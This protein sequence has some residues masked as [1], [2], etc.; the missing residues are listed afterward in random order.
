M[1]TAKALKNVVILLGVIVLV[2]GTYFVYRY[3]TKH[4]LDQ[5]RKAIHEKSNAVILKWTDQSPS[6]L[7]QAIMNV[8]LELDKPVLPKVKIILEKSKS[9]EVRAAAAFA[10][11]LFVAKDG[12][13]R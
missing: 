9:E 8:A 2:L 1:R 10:L 5:G 11:F 6:Q 12:I 13:I 7:Y 4:A 3:K